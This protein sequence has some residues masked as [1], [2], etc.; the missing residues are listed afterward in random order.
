MRVTVDETLCEAQGFC[1]SLAPDIF[2]LGDEDVVQIADGP[3]PP[4]REIDVRAAVEQCP[5]AALRIHED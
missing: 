1:E 5:K 2:E 3:V 4:D